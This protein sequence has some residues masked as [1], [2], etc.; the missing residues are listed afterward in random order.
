MSHNL[1]GEI[2]LDERITK[3]IRIAQRDGYEGCL[4]AVKI[5]R[6]NLIGKAK[7]EQI[8]VLNAVIYKLEEAEKELFNEL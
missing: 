6:D 3:N 2:Y 1:K 5:C 8:D 7:E 4:M